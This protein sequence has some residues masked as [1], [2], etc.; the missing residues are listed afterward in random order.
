MLRLLSKRRV[1]A[2]KNGGVA[3]TYSISGTVYDADGSTPVSGA[4]VVLGVYS[5]ISGGDGTYTITGISAGTSGSMT[6][7]KTGYSWAAKS[8]A[9]MSGNLTGQNYTNAWWAAG[10]TAA[11]NTG[12]YRAIG[13][14]S[15]P[16]SLVNVLDPGTDDLTSAVNP[17]FAA[18]TGWTYDGTKKILCPIVLPAGSSLVMRYAN[19]SGNGLMFGKAVA[20]LDFAL[21][22]I[23][24]IKYFDNG[25]QVNVANAATGGVIALT[26]YGYLD[27]I[28]IT[29][30]MLGTGTCPNGIGIGANRTSA[31]ANIPTYTG[32]ILA[33]VVAPGTLW[34]PTQVIAL[35]NALAALTNP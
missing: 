20:S 24:G 33:F 2:F 21:Q 31:V 4:T 27:G 16:A 25:N 22:Q 15:F 17:T 6:C 35:S 28:A 26:D 12:A 10:G 9:T 32:D 3:P 23:G 8:I 34:T 19:R 13:A 11:V 29:S 1:P 30:Q 5:A 18:A 14:V 7:T